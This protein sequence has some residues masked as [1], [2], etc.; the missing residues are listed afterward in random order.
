LNWTRLAFW[1]KLAAECFD[2]LPCRA[3][4]EKIQSVTI[5]CGCGPGARVRALLYGGWLAAQLRWT[6]PV[7]ATRIR[8]DCRK[9]PD[10]TVVG[11]LSA[12]LRTGDATICVRKD[13][14]EHTASAQ[15]TM[16]NV[17][18]L[19]RKRAFWPEDDAS[20]LSQELDRLDSDPVHQRALTMAAALVPLLPET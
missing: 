10:A 7:A 2:D 11:L 20:L 9:D 5:T 13:Y 18:G 6:P 15:I 3:A 4:L 16:A 14:G 19:P 12:E 8:V 1:R 17:C